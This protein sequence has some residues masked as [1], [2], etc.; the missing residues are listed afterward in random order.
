MNG[1]TTLWIAN[2]LSLIG[3]VIAASAAFLKSKRNILLFQS[4]NHVLEIVAQLLTDAY[5]GVVQEVIS[6]IRNVTFVFVKSP[7]KAP[8]LI[9]SLLCLVAG[10]AVGVWFNILFSNNV[11]YGYLPIA[12]AAVYAIFVIFAFLMAADD[13]TSEL[14]IKI[15]ILFNAICFS[16]YG[17]FIKLYPVV[18]FN[19]AAF[20]LAVISIVRISV[21]KKKSAL[22]PAASEDEGKET[23]SLTEDTI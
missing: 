12:G 13:L 9:V 8:K 10:L 5:S 7:K 18:A 22:P 17:V 23:A 1:T 11:L 6:L 16:A 15:G 2:I 20:V 14:L 4:S 19:G 21:R 3:N